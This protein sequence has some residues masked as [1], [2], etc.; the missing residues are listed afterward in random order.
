MKIDLYTK[1]IL[2]IIAVC[3]VCLVLNSGNISLVTQAQAQP[4]GLQASKPVD[5][6]IV[7]ID[8]KTFG[9]VQISLTEPSLPVQ[10]LS[11]R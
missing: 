3:L 7:S 10:I 9:P 5:V 1:I 8:G 11:K 4:T 6:N 2:T